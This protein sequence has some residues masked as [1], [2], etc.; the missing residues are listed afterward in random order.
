MATITVRIPDQ[1]RDALQEKAE[2][3]HQTLSDF[4]RD[5]LQDAV[6]ESPE[7]TERRPSRR[8]ETLTLVDRQTLALLHR[9]LARVLPDDANDEDGDETYQI[10]RASVLEQGFAGE[11]S[12]EFQVLSEEL[13]IAQCEF[14]V[15]VLGMFQIAKWSIE[16]LSEE[17]GQLTD[18]QLYALTFHGF[19]FNDPTEGHMGVY[20]RHLVT[21]DRWAEQMDF[22]HQGERGNS[23]MPMR[24]AYSRMLAEYRNREQRPLAR[25][26]GL[27][28]KVELEQLAAA[29]IH[30]D[31]R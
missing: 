2:A 1:T 19:D 31:N 18:D 30:P 29:A 6:N 17:D 13:S 28:T 10:E 3:A 23:H 27:L 9:I 26:S 22:V 11:Y 20:V 16:A 25:R 7:R 24:A 15:D 8:I 5:H 4:V 12:T 21:E 14:V